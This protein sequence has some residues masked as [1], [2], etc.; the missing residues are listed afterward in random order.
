[1]EEIMQFLKYFSVFTFLASVFSGAME[2][3][4]INTQNS[5][6]QKLHSDHIQ[7][8]LLDAGSL[9]EIGQCA[10]ALSC[11]N[12][13]LNTVINSVANNENLIPA[14]AARLNM[15]P[16]DVAFGLRTVGARTWL[17]NNV[18]EHIYRELK[19][20][21]AYQ[22]QDYYFTNLNNPELAREK[23]KQICFLAQ[24]LPRITEVGDWPGLTRITLKGFP[25]VTKS[26]I[27][28]GI[29]V[30]LKNKHGKTALQNAC[31]S[32]ALEDAQL[33]LNAGAEVTEDAL[34]ELT[35]IWNDARPEAARKAIHDLLI[36]AKQKQ[37]QEKNGCSIL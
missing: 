16:N 15:H 18:D 21:Y 22:F 12:R 19:E 32:G 34:Y 33:L 10:R 17:R 26:L 6:I 11:V 4:V 9:Q 37:E 35:H 14:I 20:L 2:R 28:A 3:P 25:E 5:P 31:Y 1:M 8:I 36:R 30:N 24:T 27:K 23:L 7:N 13:G 29:N